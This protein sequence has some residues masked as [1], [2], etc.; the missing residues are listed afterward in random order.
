MSA[1]VVANRTDDEGPPAGE[2]GR[3][4]R[5]S[6]PTEATLDR[7][8]LNPASAVLAGSPIPDH[9]GVRILGEPG[10]QALEHVDRAGPDDHDA[11]P[12]EQHGDQSCSTL[13]ATSARILKCLPI[14][15]IC[16]ARISDAAQN[17]TD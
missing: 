11:L 12:A 7:Y 3:S 10:L 14:M 2:Q 13:H 16:G 1:G 6:A 4:V 5:M 15:M 17:L 9:N 8:A